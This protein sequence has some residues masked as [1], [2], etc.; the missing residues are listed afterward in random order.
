MKK[1]H[2]PLLTLASLFAF[3]LPLA[4][5]RADILMIDLHLSNDEVAAAREAAQDRGEKLVVVPVVSTEIRRQLG[6]L[7]FRALRAEN[8]EKE[9]AKKLKAAKAAD[10]V[11]PAEVRRLTQREKE[12]KAD[13]TDLENQ[14]SAIEKKL[15]NVGSDMIRKAIQGIEASH[16]TLTSL[17]ISGHSNGLEFWGDEWEVTRQQIK[18]I[19]D[20]LPASKKSL[21]S[22]FLWGCYSAERGDIEWWKSAFPRLQVILGFSD[23][24]PGAGSDAS[25]NL[26]RDALGREADMARTTDIKSASRVFK[27]LDDVEETNAAAA[28]NSCYFGTHFA[29]IRLD[30]VADCPGAED[31]LRKGF[32][33]FSSCFAATSRCP[34][35]PRETH[36]SDLRQYY[37]DYLEYAHCRT[38]SRYVEGLPPRE[39]VLALI[40]FANVRGNFALYYKSQIEA[41]NAYLAK[42]GGLKFPDLGAK[43]ATRTTILHQ[44]NELRELGPPASRNS[45]LQKL[46]GHAD[47]LVGTLDCVPSTWMTEEPESGHSLAA[48]AC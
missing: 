1:S 32:A 4:Q 26:L 19:L 7:S 12:L 40:F 6:D 31:A 25:P 21:R 22:V 39:R 34:D 2:G 10:P 17:I 44:L 33:V 45:D 36:G 23:V 42:H 28:I 29:P 18:G 11:D 37:T 30:S 20:G 15:P 47:T 8:R 5:A 41:A 24:A 46:I 13:L 48:P 14:K 27:S 38:Q 3:A 35:P 9:G 16:H 43:D